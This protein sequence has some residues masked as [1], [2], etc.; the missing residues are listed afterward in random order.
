[1]AVVSVSRD[2]IH[3]KLSRVYSLIALARTTETNERQDFLT[4]GGGR[5]Y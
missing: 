1:M 3:T 4:G 5:L 2:G